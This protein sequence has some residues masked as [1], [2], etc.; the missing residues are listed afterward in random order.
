MK[1][2]K[3]RLIRILGCLMLVAALMS[4]ACG[5]T[6]TKNGQKEVTDEKDL[7]QTTPDAEPD[8]ELDKGSDKYTHTLQY[9]NFDT[10][11]TYVIAEYASFVE[12]GVSMPLAKTITEFK[13]EK[14]D[15]IITVKIPSQIKKGTYTIQ[16]VITEKGDDEHLAFAAESNEIKDDNVTIKFE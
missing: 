14:E 1:N 13:P 15:G 4:T 3:Y 10:E 7:L 9:N 6:E 11:K 5:K 2:K 8:Y 16:T 12:D